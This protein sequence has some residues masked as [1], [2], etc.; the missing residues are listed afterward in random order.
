MTG[1]LRIG[2]FAIVNK[3]QCAVMRHR[4]QAMRHAAKTL[5]TIGNRGI[6]QPQALPNGQSGGGVLAIMGAAKG[7]TIL[8]IKRLASAIMQ[9]P[10]REMNI[11][12]ARGAGNRD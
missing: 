1:R 9:A 11:A 2:G 7:R 5:E 3:M 12:L 4:L 6:A 10:L 8:Q